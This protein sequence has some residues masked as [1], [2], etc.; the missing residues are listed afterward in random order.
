M[1]AIIDFCPAVQ[2]VERRLAIKESA[3]LVFAYD[4]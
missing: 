3:F 2:A 4:F 1:A